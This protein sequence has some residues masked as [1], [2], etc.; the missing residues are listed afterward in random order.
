MRERGNQSVEIRRG[1]GGY[2]A[3][4]PFSMCV[5]LLLQV[6]VC[7]WVSV[8]RWC[9]LMCMCLLPPPNI[10]LFPRSRAFQSGALSLPLSLSYFHLF[11][12]YIPLSFF[13]SLCECSAIVHSPLDWVVS[14]REQFMLITPYCVVTIERTFHNSPFALLVSVVSEHTLTYSLALC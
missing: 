3:L 9:K 13:L 1:V 4:L 5:C 10:L 12:S 8:F 14:S 7:V 11:L 2:K 6:C